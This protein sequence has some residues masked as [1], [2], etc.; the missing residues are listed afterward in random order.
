MS[1]A[2]KEDGYQTMSPKIMKYEGRFTSM[3]TRQSN[4]MSAGIIGFRATLRKGQPRQGQVHKVTLAYTVLSE[5]TI[6][7][8]PSYVNLPML[9][10]Y[11]P[12]LLHD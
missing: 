8:R 10:P 4:V 5:K 3:H 12:Q 9:I 6:N 11:T 2:I 7:Y 1:S